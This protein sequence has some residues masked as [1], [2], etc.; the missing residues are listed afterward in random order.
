[1]GPI[2]SED[3]VGG[4][5]APLTSATMSEVLT[6]EIA[7]LRTLFHAVP[8]GEC[9]T[10]PTT[11]TSGRVYLFTSG[12]GNADDGAT[13]QIDEVAVWAPRHNVP[14]SVTAGDASLLF[15]ELVIDL[16]P[17]DLTELEQQ[18][19]LFPLFIS[20]SNCRTY[21]EKIKSDKTISR[22][23]LPEHTYPRL[24]IGS[25]Q[26]TGDDRVAAHEH[27]MLEQLFF[28]LQHNQCELQADAASLAFGDGVLLHIPLGSRHGVTV[29]APNELHYVWIDLFRNRQG[30]QWIVD[31]HKHDP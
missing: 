12:N 11:E 7:G 9:V 21:R 24:C 13:Q 5:G 1:M 28:G 31:E 14:L 19:H 17:T 8:P 30:M 6:G 26:T 29:Q 20:Y 22:T 27:P 23:L 4:I 15:L 3:L 25:V 16:S 2:H 18:A 10:L